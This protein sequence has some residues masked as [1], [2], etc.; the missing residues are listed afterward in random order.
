MRLLV[1]A[2]LMFMLT[3]VSAQE[4]RCAVQVESR[5]VQ[6]TNRSVFETMQKDLMEFMNNMNWTDHIYTPE[7]RIECNILINIQEV[8]SSDEFKGS[9]QVQARRPVYNTSY[10]TVLF[11]WKDQD[12]H[13]RYVENQPLIYNP[14]TFDSNLIAVLAY[15][16][17]MILGFDYDSFKLYGGTPYYQKA[18]NIVNRAQQAR[19]SGWKSFENKRN[20][21]W[22]TEKVMNEYHRPLRKCMYEYHIKGLDVMQEKTEEGRAQILKSLEE[23]RRIQRQDP[24]SVM[25]QVFFTAKSDELVNIFTESFSM[26]KGRAVNLL[27][28]VDPS[29]I[30]KYEK[31]TAAQ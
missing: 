21:Y 2:S 17:Y 31:L 18:E 1:V 24:G 23:L 20:R 15:Y 22:I 27:K 4:F 10:N 25:L 7:E 28:E 30:T 26:E 3:M 6:G 11:N 16:A 14:N 13:F 9:I 19:E 12:M 8:I 29:N 5:K